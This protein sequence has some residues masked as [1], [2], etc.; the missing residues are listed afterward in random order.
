MRKF[1][2][3]NVFFTNID[4]AAR[5]KIES[6]TNTQEANGERASVVCSIYLYQQ[7]RNINA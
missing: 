7:T 1:S 2:F 3:E 6:G 4:F 5:E